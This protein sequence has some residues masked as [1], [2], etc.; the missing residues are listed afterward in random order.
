MQKPTCKECKHFRT[1]YVKIDNH[2]Y[3]TAG[4][5]HCVYPRLKHRKPETFACVYFVKIAAQSRK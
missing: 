4:C 1:H 3:E 2:H 5:G